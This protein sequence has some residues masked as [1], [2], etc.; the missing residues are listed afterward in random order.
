M[1]PAAGAAGAANTEVSAAEVDHW[2]RS[3]RI[4]GCHVS[5]RAVSRFRKLGCAP[6]VATYPAADISQQNL[7][8][9]MTST[10][11]TVTLKLMLDTPVLGRKS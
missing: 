9:F 2:G 8:R 10:L 3:S 11:P 4:A 5:D 1:Q 7:P 6:R